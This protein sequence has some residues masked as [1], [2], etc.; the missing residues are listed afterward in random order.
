MYHGLRLSS[1]SGASQDYSI[2]SKRLMAVVDWFLSWLGA[3][4]LFCSILLFPET[5]PRGVLLQG[6]ALFALD[7]GIRY[8]LA[9]SVVAGALGI[10]LEG[11]RRYPSRQ[12]ERPYLG[13]GGAPSPKDLVQVVKLVLAAGGLTAAL[14]LVCAVLV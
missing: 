8:K 2:F 14:I 10:T 12:V 6:R 1:S 3:L 4:C 11:P 7:P 5:S 13:F 9:K